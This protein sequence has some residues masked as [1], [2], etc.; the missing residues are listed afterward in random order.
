[1]KSIPQRIRKQIEHD[2]FYWYDVIDHRSRNVVQHH[3]L[4]YKKSQIEWIVVP[5]TE[6]NHLKAHFKIE[7]NARENKYIHN[8]CI[9]IAIKRNI[10]ELLKQCPKKD[11]VQEWRKAEYILSMNK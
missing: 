9:A 8:K 5:L 10:G 3:P 2:P 6:L 7:K 4:Y 1:M 11:W